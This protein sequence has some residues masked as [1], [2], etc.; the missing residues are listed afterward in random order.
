M[1][2]KGV[3]LVEILIAAFIFAVTVVG[4]T[5][6]FISGKRW[7]MHANARVTNIEALGKNTL[8]DLQQ[9]VVQS[10]WNLTTNNY[11][12]SN[13]LTTGTRIVP[14]TNPFLNNVNA[15]VSYTVSL[16]PAIST[17]QMRKVKL[18]INWTEISPTP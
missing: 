14:V 13:S 6:I 18:T 16:P 1:Q 10:D 12:P 15:T 4:L 7:V 8:E 3:T 5:N 17:T 11:N 2:K 9:Q